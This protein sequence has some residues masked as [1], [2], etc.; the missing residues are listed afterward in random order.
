MDMDEASLGEALYDLPIVRIDYFTETDSTNERALAALGEQ[1]AREEY[2]LMVAERQTAGRGRMGRSWIT[3]PGASLA[4]TLLIH[5][6]K[7]EEQKLGLF[8]LLGALSIC[9]SLTGLC[10]AR[11]QVKWPNDVLLDGRKTAGVLAESRWDGGQIRGIALGMGINVLPESVPTG[12]NLLFPATCVQAH[13]EQP[14][15]PVTVLRAVLREL[16]SLRPYLL[17]LR[18][19]QA[20]INCLAY[21]GEDVQLTLPHNEK[22]HG[23]LAGIDAT[24]QLILKDADGLETCYPIGDLRLR[25]DRV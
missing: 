10:G 19:F 8:S 25:P 4:A 24:G 18:F 9:R 20:Y 15:D 11:A 17:E 1:G 16:F 2:I 7:T 23:K 5:P 6:T 21:V 13:C 22:V 12:Q 14:V 3:T